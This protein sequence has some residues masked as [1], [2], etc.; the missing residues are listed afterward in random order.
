MVI[1]K[2]HLLLVSVASALQLCF[3][4]LCFVFALVIFQARHTLTQH[5]PPGCNTEVYGV[6]PPVGWPAYASHMSFGELAPED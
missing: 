5:P 2:V 1:L 4:L 6:A 3:A